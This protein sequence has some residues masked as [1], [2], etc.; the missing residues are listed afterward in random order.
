[1]ITRSAPLRR[2]PLKRKPRRYVVPPEILAYWEWIRKQRCAVPNCLSKRMPLPFFRMS[3]MEAA[4]IGMRGLSQKCD[5]WEVIPL[6]L[7]HHQRGLPHS[8]H[9]LG[10][11]FWSFH[12]IERYGLIRM[13]LKRYFGLTG[14]EPANVGCGFDMEGL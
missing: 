12:G 10:K 8:H 6:C 9:T 5:G 1:M 3:T 14:L 7:L 11:R 13:Y 4:H 2:S